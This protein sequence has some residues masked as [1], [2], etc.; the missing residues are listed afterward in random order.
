[1]GTVA[2]PG[3][4][5]GRV[6]RGRKYKNCLNLVQNKGKIRRLGG[7]NAPFAPLNPPPYGGGGP[8]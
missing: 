1:M 4:N 7:A 6:T 3:F 2:D 8:E 5:F